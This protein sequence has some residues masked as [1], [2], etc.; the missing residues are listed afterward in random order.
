MPSLLSNDKERIKKVVNN[1]TE[2]KNLVYT[3]INSPTNQKR[4]KYKYYHKNANQT[5]KTPSK[6]IKKKLTL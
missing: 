4:D 6:K 1:I 3:K 5:T 2:V